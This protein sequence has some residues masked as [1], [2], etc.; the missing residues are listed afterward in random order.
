MIIRRAEDA[1]QR[2]KA[3][4]IEIGHTQYSYERRGRLR[5][6]GFATRS[7]RNDC[8]LGNDL[9]AHKRGG[10]KLEVNN[11]PRRPKLPMRSLK[12]LERKK[13]SEEF[14]LREEVKLL[15]LRVTRAR[16]K[17]AALCAST[18]VAF[19]AFALL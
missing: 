18:S 8:K 13:E 17:C 6:A 7:T 9:I 11:I 10:Y 19:F 16:R 5:V 15:D 4:D 2:H 14:Y 3:N 1:A 12:Y